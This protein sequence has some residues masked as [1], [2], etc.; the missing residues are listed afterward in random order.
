M[1]LVGFVPD[2]KEVRDGHWEVGVGATPLFSLN[3]SDP[4]KFLPQ[5]NHCSQVG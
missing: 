3:C 4:D 1:E 2:G 5:W